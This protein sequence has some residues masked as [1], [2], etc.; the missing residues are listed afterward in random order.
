MKII[1]P[2]ILSADFSILKDQIKQTEIGGAGWIHCDV[3]DGQFVPNITFGTVVIDAAKK[4]TSL[5]LDVHLMI[6][7]PDSL[8]PNFINAGASY[9]T[10]HIEEVVH[11]HRTLQ[12]IKE[13]GAKPGLVLNPSTPLNLSFEV[14]EEIDLLLLM[15][16]NPGFGGQS[17]IKNVL[18]KIEEAANY[19]EKK[20]LKYLI[21]VDGGV[22]KNNIKDISNA[23]CDVFVAG[24]SI[25]HSE[26]ITIAT[27]ELLTMIKE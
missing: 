26:N 15:S 14:L 24:S 16:V 4:S 11:I 9:I 25:F 18:R 1:A 7:N 3:M 10:V 2:S 17:F 19:R 20:N 12:K 8:I 6:K 22:T 5:P 23:G 13:L 21:E 27:Q